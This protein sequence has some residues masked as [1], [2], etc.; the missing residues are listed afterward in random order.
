MV[1]LYAVAL[2]L[3]VYCGLDL[4]RTPASQVRTLPKLLWLLVLLAP[5]FGPA[6]WL[7]AGRPGGK[8]P[9]RVAPTRGA[10][11]DDDDFLRELRRRAEDRRRRSRDP[12]DDG[13]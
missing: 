8:G 7:L 2:V 1:F 3:L 6:A 11:D 13:L 4:L 9:Q 10:P 5:V 12:R